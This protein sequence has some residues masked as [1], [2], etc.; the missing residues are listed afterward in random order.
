MVV[1]GVYEDCFL[2][3]ISR[4]RRERLLCWPGHCGHWTLGG[5]HSAQHSAWTQPTVKTRRRRL[6]RW[7]RVCIWIVSFDKASYCMYQKVAR[8]IS[9][10]L[11][12]ISL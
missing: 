4:M 5:T 10:Y 9:T 12:N 2:A 1:C 11:H 8:Y 6:L 7:A 3:T